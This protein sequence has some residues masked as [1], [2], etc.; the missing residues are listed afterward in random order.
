[1]IG[2]VSAY[3]LDRLLGH[4]INHD[5]IHF[6]NIETLL[7]NRGRDKDIE[8]SFLELLDRLADEYSFEYT[9]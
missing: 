3:E 7:P 8:F 2:K 1:V 6:T 4:I 9:E 5:K